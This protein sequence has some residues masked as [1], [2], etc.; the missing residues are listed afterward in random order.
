MQGR[1]EW[2][3]AGVVVVVVV[4][5]LAAA[6]LLSSP[7]GST[8]DAP[9]TVAQAQEAEVSMTATSTAIATSMPT[10]M[11]TPTQAS[12][13]LS[14]TPSVTVAQPSASASA[15]LAV[16]STQ[17]VVTTAAQSANTETPSATHT[18]TATRTPT[19]TSTLTRT[20]TVTHTATLTQTPTATSTLTRTP[21]ATRTPTHTATITPSATQ[22]PLPTETP[23]AQA[24]V[25]PAGWVSYR[26]QLGNTL[27]SIAR[28]VGSTTAALRDAN[29]LADENLLYEGQEL[30]VPRLPSQPVPVFG[31]QSSTSALRASGCL[32]PETQLSAPA[33]GARV[34]GTFDL[35]GTATRDSFW[36]YKIEIRRDGV[37]GYDFYADGYTPV[38]DGVLARIDTRIFG[39][40]LYF[41]RLSVVDERG[42]I[43]ADAFC[44]IP[45]YFE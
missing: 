15:T 23:Q 12:V 13:S 5:A 35:I 29:C 21:T 4:F 8:A 1:G 45:L 30:F 41:V 2:W 9:T 26:V 42:S 43:K 22:T 31:Q 32:V 33:V 18:P 17:R 27:F 10:L 24:C 44:E 6:W 14:V 38:Q 34:S 11:A 28:A 40:G 7:E 3:I 20:P 19:A 39:T 36:Y 37:S 16:T 25:K